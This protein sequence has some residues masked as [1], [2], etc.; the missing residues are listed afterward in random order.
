MVSALNYL[1]EVLS[2]RAG[3]RLTRE[4]KQA[5]LPKSELA[6][7]YTHSICYCQI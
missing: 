1:L 3:Y 2:V 5:G 7:E 4:T 6:F